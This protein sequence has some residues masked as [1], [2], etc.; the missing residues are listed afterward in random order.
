LLVYYI[1]YNIWHCLVSAIRIVAIFKMF[2]GHLKQNCQPLSEYPCMIRI[3]TDIYNV[4]MPDRIKSI[5]H[6]PFLTSFLLYRDI[7]RQTVVSLISE[8]IALFNTQYVYRHSTRKYAS[9]RDK[10]TCDKGRVGHNNVIRTEIN[11]G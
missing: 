6:V 5:G 9:F 10:I 1:L 4:R 7:W 2:L 8:A 11:S 3:R